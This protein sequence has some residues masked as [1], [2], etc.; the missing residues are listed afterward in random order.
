MK[1]SDHNPY[2]QAFKQALDG[3]DPQLWAHLDR[4][5]VLDAATQR[6]I[7]NYLLN[8]ACQATHYRNIELGRAALV[9]L[10]RTWLLE[11]LDDAAAPLLALND[12][13]EFRR[14]GDVYMLLDRHRANILL[15][16]GL[17]STNANIREAAQ[18]LLQVLADDRK[19]S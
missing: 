7:L 12:D 18:D 14:L 4:V 6:A 15:H 2:D 19:G 13:W 16:Q 1:L 3:Y 9:A 8:L 5:P 17:A 10:P 11:H